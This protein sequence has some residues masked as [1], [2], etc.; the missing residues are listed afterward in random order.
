SAEQ[1]RVG[2]AA[3]DDRALQRARGGVLAD[4]VAE[5]LRA[6]LAVQGLVL[7]HVFS[8][9]SRRDRVLSPI[10][11]IRG[12]EADDRHEW[13]RTPA[14]TREPTRTAVRGSGPDG[15]GTPGS[16]PYRCFLPDLTGFG[17]PSCAG[18]NLSTPFAAAGREKPRPQHG[19]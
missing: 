1:V 15:C 2:D 6:V 9:R 11:R 4:Q 14:S 17:D 12:G 3:R 13:P 8:S 5:S 7:R 10:P 18:P 19:N 16:S